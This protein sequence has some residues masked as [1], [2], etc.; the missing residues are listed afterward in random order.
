LAVVHADYCS[1]G[2]DFVATGVK[3][4]ILKIVTILGWS[5]IHVVVF[6]IAEIFIAELLDPVE[7]WV[8]R[9]CFWH[10]VGGVNVQILTSFD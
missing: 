5:V 1:L 4:C 2:E 3:S 9:S 6:R 10:F 8:L 7:Q